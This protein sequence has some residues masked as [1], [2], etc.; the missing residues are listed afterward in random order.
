MSLSPQTI[1]SSCIQVVSTRDRASAHAIHRGATYVA[2]ETT[3]I[4]SCIDD[5]RTHTHIHSRVRNTPHRVELVYS[6][7]SRYFIGF[8]TSLRPPL[9]L[10]R[11][12]VY[13]LRRLFLHHALINALENAKESLAPCNIIDVVPHLTAG[14]S[15]FKQREEAGHPA[16]EFGLS[17]RHHA[18]ASE[19]AL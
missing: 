13:R 8:L 12:S 7:S 18:R 1:S 11:G 6:S 14:F 5:H 19:C 15:Y 10:Q 9:C 17:F 2:S 16:L 4:Q 3:R